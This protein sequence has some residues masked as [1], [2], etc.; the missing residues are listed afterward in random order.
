METLT[1]I[2]SSGIATHLAAGAVGWL[3]A[4]AYANHNALSGVITQLKTDVA[5]I[6]GHLN[7][8]ANTAPVTPATP[9]S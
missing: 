1:T 3:G 2:L 7:A 4:V 6:K 9:A 8:K 5:E